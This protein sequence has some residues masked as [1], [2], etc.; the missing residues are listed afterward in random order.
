MKY[1]VLHLAIGIVLIAM[2]FSVVGSIA[3]LLYGPGVTIIVPDFFGSNKATTTKNVA[4]DFLD[5]YAGT[6]F[7][8]DGA[9][10]LKAEFLENSM[11]LVLSDGRQIGLSK[12]I[13]AS[14]TRYANTDESFIFHTKDNG[15]SVEENGVMTYANCAT[16]MPD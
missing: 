16:T 5:G 2:I 1:S 15:A 8:C 4:T 12:I 10:A 6:P 14:G 13:S 7:A 3:Y 9:N 11:R